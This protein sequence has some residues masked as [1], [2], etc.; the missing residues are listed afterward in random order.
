MAEEQKKKCD[1]SHTYTLT[2]T[3]TL[4]HI[5]THSHTHT[6]THTLTHSLSPDSVQ[7]ESCWLLVRTMHV[8]TS[9]APV[10]PVTTAYLDVDIAGAYPVPSPAWTGHMTHVTYRQEINYL[11]VPRLSIVTSIA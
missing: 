2:H 8:W 3:H 5:L 10:T 6:L 11:S 7:M 1:I 4:T 9:T